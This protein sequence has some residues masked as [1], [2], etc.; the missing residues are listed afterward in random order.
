MIIIVTA[1]ASPQCVCTRVHMR[2]AAG[3]L[4][5]SLNVLPVQVL[6]SLFNAYPSLQE[7]TKL[8][9]VL[10]QVCSHGDDAH[11]SMSTGIKLIYELAMYNIIAKH[12][13]LYVQLYITAIHVFLN[14]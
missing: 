11:S 1:C 3:L 10:V 2:V 4:F 5:L 8:P 13:Q 9:G 6:P 7:H 12:V 14:R